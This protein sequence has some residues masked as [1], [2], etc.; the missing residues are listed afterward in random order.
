M[1]NKLINIKLICSY[2]ENRI[3]VSVIFLSRDVKYLLGS[4]SE[5]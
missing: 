5:M 1:I 2:F 3:I 4:A